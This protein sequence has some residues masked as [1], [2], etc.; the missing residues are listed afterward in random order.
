LAGDL[1]DAALGFASGQVL[2]GLLLASRRYTKYEVAGF[3][4]KAAR[5]KIAQAMIQANQYAI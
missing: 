5:R 4:P 2:D 3:N 1:Q